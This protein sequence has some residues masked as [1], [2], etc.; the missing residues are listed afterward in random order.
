MEES[1]IRSPSSFPNKPDLEP[2]ITDPES[3][4]QEV[5][6]LV[7]P[8]P[9]S[10]APEE[11][12][13]PIPND[14]FVKD[15]TDRSSPW[16]VI[17]LILG[18]L[19]LLLMITSIF[20]GYQY[21]QN[22]QQSSSNMDDLTKE[23]ESFHH[24]VENFTGTIK[25][26]QED[27]LGNL[28]TQIEKLFDKLKMQKMKQGNYFEPCLKHWKQYEDNCY[29][30]TLNVASWYDCSKLC[31][32]MNSTFLQS[33]NDMLMDFMKTMTLNDTWV[34][35]NYQKGSEKWE[36]MDGSSYAFSLPPKPEQN[37]QDLCVYV[38]LHTVDSYQCNKTLPCMC[39]K[40]ALSVEN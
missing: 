21:F 15:I 39:E 38:K 9:L 33:G 20:F 6:T 23:L 10:A 30:Q 7:S 28:K 4:E 37:F 13:G 40:A 12:W 5:T 27:I 36:W 11:E 14:I 34:G 16:E 31:D 19:C 32:S 24:E 2:S 3:A 8:L 35:I 29:H 22:T 17:A 1:S 25:K 26:T 18:V